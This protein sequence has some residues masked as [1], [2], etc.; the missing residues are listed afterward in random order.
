MESVKYLAWHLI[1]T[2]DVVCLY[3][4]LARIETFNRKQ[5]IQWINQCLQHSR[6]I[7]TVL[8]QKHLDEIS[9]LLNQGDEGQLWIA[10]IDFAYYVLIF[11]NEKVKAKLDALK[12]LYS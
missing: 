10:Y 8:T 7:K 6:Q 5:V 2:C 12:G 1:H 9:I 4:K 11:G 3:E